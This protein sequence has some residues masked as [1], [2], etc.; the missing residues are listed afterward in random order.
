MPL[1]DWDAAPGSSVLKDC[2]NYYWIATLP[3]T[4]GVMIIWSLCLCLPWR[5]WATSI[6]CSKRRRGEADSM[7]V[8]YGVENVI[9]LD[10]WANGTASYPNPLIESN[11]V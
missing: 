5:K 1:F 7:E 9:P 2:F 3:L 11:R 10:D 4:I 8:K 6:G